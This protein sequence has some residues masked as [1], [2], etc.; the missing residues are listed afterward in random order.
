[1]TVLKSVAPWRK[2]LAR[3]AWLPL[4]QLA[5]VRV[6]VAP[7]Q[8]HLG[9]VDQD[10]HDS[11]DD[12]EV[13]QHLHTDQDPPIVRP[14]RDVT[15][16]NGGKDSD[17]EVQGARVV[18]RLAER[19]PRRIVERQIKRSEEHEEEG[20]DN[21]KRLGGSQFGYLRFDDMAGLPGYNCGDQN[22]PD[23]KPKDVVNSRLFTGG[24]DVVNPDE[25]DPRP[26]DYHGR[27]RYGPPPFPAFQLRNSSGG[28]W[29]NPCSACSRPNY[30]RNASLTSE[31]QVLSA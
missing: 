28:Q 20:Q 30:V 8:A 21:A 25:D 12:D 7:G 29:L 31:I 23:R 17:G 19:G 6:V 3:P 5:V 15:E 9:C 1:M 2:K 24:H 18:E 26:G 10:A 22:E 13:E 16:A 14:R 4:A 27:A 11:S